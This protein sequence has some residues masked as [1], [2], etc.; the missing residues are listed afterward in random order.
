METW[1]EGNEFQFQWPY[2]LKAI[3]SLK[4]ESKFNEHVKCSLVAEMAEEDAEVCLLEG[5]FQDS[6]R[7]FKRTDEGSQYWFTGGITSLEIEVE[8]GIPHVKVEALSRSYAMDLTPHSRSF[9]NKH[10]T[11]TGLIQKLASIYPKGDILNEATNPGDTIGELMVQYQET[12]WQFLKRLASRIGT[13]IL[14][15]VV[16][17]AP[18]VYFGVPDFKWGTVIHAKKYT[19]L[20]NRAV[21]LD[22]KAHTDGGAL[23]EN[24]L[25][26][27]L[28]VTDQYCQ[29]GDNVGFKGRMWVIAESAITYEKGTTSYTYLLVQRSSLR[30]KSRLNK[31][32]QGVALEGRV[33]KRA[34]NMVKVHLDIDG[35]H[36]ESGNWWFPYSP[37]GNNIFHCMPDEGARIKIY[38]PNG[39]EKQSIAINSVR[40]RS[41]EMTSR[42]VFQKPTTKVFHMPGEAK[43]ELGDD[44][45][46]FEKG[47]VRIHLNQN[48]IRLEADS[49]LFVS[50]SNNLN[51]GSRDAVINSIKLTASDFI[52]FQTFDSQQSVTVQGNRVGIRSKELH[53]EKVEMDYIELLTDEE[54]K[55]L[56]VDQLTE[57][58]M[59][60]VYLEKREQN[61]ISYDELEA[62][63]SYK[64]EADN[65]KKEDVRKI[66]AGRVEEDPNAKP[67]AL[68]KM[69]KIDGI[70]LRDRYRKKFVISSNGEETT[71]KDLEEQ[72]QKY[73]NAYNQ[74]KA[75]KQQQYEA[76]NKG[77]EERN[78]PVPST[79]SVPESSG[80]PNIGR[81][82]PFTGSVQALLGNAIEAFMKE[83]ELNLIVPQKP[84]YLSKAEDKSLLYSRYTF[85]QFQISPQIMF[86]EMNI[87]FGAVAIVGAFFTGGSSLLMLSLAAGGAVLGVADIG[88]NVQKIN[89][90]NEGKDYTHP[91][92]MGMNQDFVNIAGLVVGA[93]ELGLGLKALL[94]SGDL[95]A[96]ARNIDELDEVLD[97]GLKRGPKSG[98]LIEETD[99]AA[100]IPRTGPEWD[101]YFRSRYGDQNVDW[102]TSSEYKLYGEKH[103]PYTPKIRPNA[104]ITKPSLPKG[105]KPKG[106]YANEKGKNAR[107]LK[108]Q[109][110]AANVLA[111]NGYRTIM[112]DEVPNGKFRGNGYGI[113]PD[114]SPD[115]IIEG[116]VFD[117]YAPESTKLK[118]TLDILR[119]KTTLQARRIVLNLNDYPVENRTELIEFI[120]SQ[121]HKDLK[122]LNELLVIEG[123]QVTRA[124]WRFE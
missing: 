117:C 7:I 6:L 113:D 43:M 92:F 3:R 115:F 110:E 112:L 24:D 76:K 33:V 19:L 66:I 89:D 11:Y 101:E 77:N 9:Q 72:K 31:G 83:A 39:I 70:E 119:E 55:E 98:S 99:N 120:L 108:R 67:N 5:S 79:P 50:A 60:S 8:D 71:E 78:Q 34:N 27:Y 37:E 41:E 49:H 52:T 14:P 86:A 26:S 1:Q 46:L 84:N 45:V 42:T 91:T 17:D 36:D 35:E 48:D 124:Y 102:K 114:K 96:Y 87:L 105:G 40:G 28:V 56:Y 38:F 18:R 4:I 53:F 103:I 81:E 122:H 10:L 80:K 94:K 106:N 58:G 73:I 51:F 30:R 21:Y 121:T 107:G 116:Q 123:R 63:A 32:I 90:L 25:I 54:L 61:E 65:L 118:N 44:G 88:I 62:Y 57:E 23:Q 93:G 97:A 75:L 2:K 68:E 16:M 111:E 74:H 85:F 59:L 47:T 15:D 64:I 22:L 82:Q 95:A 69:S 12:D 109:N 13:V 20:S 104:V 29:V 100:K